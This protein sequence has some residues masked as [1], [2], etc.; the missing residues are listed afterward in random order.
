M[1]WKQVGLAG[2]LAPALGGCHSYHCGAHHL[3][4]ESLAISSE[5]AIT[6]DLRR[7]ARSAWREV[8]C[9]FPRKVFTEEFRD[10]FLDGYTDYLDR[11]GDASLPAVPPAR[12]TGNK[13]YYSPEGHARMKD[14]FLGFQYGMDVAVATG[15]RQFLTVPVLVPEKSP[16]PGFAVGPVGDSVGVPVVVPGPNPAPQVVI[17]T[18]PMPRPLPG[19]AT[20]PRPMPVPIPAPKLGSPDPN[21]SKFGPIG[22]GGLRPAN[23][24]ETL[25]RPNPP[26]PIP[27]PIPPTAG[28]AAVGPAD[29]KFDPVPA[30]SIRLPEPPS[31]VPSLPPEVPTPPVHDDLLVIPP[32]HTVPDPIPANHSVP[33]KD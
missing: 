12:Y 11:G 8:R 14:Y 3:V 27:I 20:G 21:G 16:P 15:C 23:P 1:R 18:E 30:V 19:P 29:T 31:E 13:K 26:L 25:P 9:Q 5:A 17:P 28:P 6:H 7:D 4:P 22:P 10:G 2:L 33:G 24:D 32:N